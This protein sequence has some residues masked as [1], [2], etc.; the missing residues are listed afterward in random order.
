M[1]HKLAVVHQRTRPSTGVCAPTPRAAHARSRLSL[2]AIARPTNETC[3]GCNLAKKGPPGAPPRTRSPPASSWRAADHRWGVAGCMHACEGMQLLRPQSPPR[4]ASSWWSH[5]R[6]PDRWS[7]ASESARPARPPRAL[8]PRHPAHGGALS[9]RPALMDGFAILHPSTALFAPSRSQL[10][11]HR[12]AHAA[13]PRGDQGG[14]AAARGEVRRVRGE[15]RE[16]AVPGA[17]GTHPSPGRVCGG[18]AWGG[19]S[20]EESRRAR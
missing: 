16:G 20:G 13:V 11:R 4:R 12:G 19:G 14:R 15:V 6:S 10:P 7:T 5:H 3:G 18:V 17:A 8:P 1:R 2:A 9:V